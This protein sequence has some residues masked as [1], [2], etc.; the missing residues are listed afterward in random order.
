[1]AAPN[2]PDFMSA[3]PLAAWV[4]TGSGAA[5][6][7]CSATGWDFLRDLQDALAERLTDGS[8]Y[9][10]F[11][12]VVVDAGDV[13]NND[14]VDQAQGWSPDTLRAL[15]AVAARDRAP[16]A[17]LA[18]VRADALRGSGA[19]SPLTLALGVWEAEFSRG[20]TAAGDP[21]Y[22]QGSPASISVPATAALPRID[23]APPAPAAGTQ[24]GVRCGAVGAPASDLQPVGQRVVPFRFDPLVV[25]AVVA[26]A[27]VVAAVVT[28]NVPS[29]TGRSG[30]KRRRRR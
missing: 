20:F 22:G 1:M 14:A 8:D 18:A 11:D 16:A 6:R 7:V 4:T 12:G 9:R 30:S 28:K 26:A 24:S 23:A 15:Y 5:A 25:F 27:A 13:P 3:A 19:V 2:P 21:V 10:S 29:A 17:Y